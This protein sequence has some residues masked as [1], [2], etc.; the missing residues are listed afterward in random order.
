MICTLNWMSTFLFVF[1]P[2]GHRKSC[3]SCWSDDCARAFMSSLALCRLSGVLLQTENVVKQ[4]LV[5]M[6]IVVVL[7]FFHVTAKVRPFTCRQRL[8]D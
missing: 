6:S 2:S 7:I 8:F 5:D 3:G 4:W 1:V